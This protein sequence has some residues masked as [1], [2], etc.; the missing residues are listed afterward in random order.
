MGKITS[1]QEKIT[2]RDSQSLSVDDR[3]IQSG[4][5]SVSFDLYG[6]TLFNKV[7]QAIQGDGSAIT[8][9]G[10]NFVFKTGSDVANGGT[11]TTGVTY[12]LV[13]YYDGSKAI[14][15]I[16]RTQIDA[17]PTI[18][19]ATVEDA[20]PDKLV[21]VFSEVVD[22]TDVSDL[23][24]AFTK[25]FDKDIESVSGSGT[26]T[27]TF[28]LSGYIQPADIFKFVWGSGNNIEDTSDHS[29]NKGS[30]SVT[31]NVVAPTLSTATVEN[32]APAD[33]VLTYSESLDTGSVPATGDFTPSGGKTVTAVAVS[34]TTVT[35]TVDT[36]YVST[37]T[38]TISYTAGANPIQDVHGNDA[39]DLTNQ[40]VTNNVV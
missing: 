27:L 23:E 29:L 28:T 24:L 11:L 30:I 18:S 37:D 15:S 17:K 25:G 7:V 10:S 34:G 26:N 6:A 20:N 9:T 22:I 32:A 14:V 2:F 13:A 39:A 4:A 35:V 5:L 21:V 16:E 38:I 40:A 12:L 33:I 36:A 31:N 3:H 8:V 19:S 1:F